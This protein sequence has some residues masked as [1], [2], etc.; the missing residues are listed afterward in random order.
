MASGLQR[1][2]AGLAFSEQ[3]G[4]ERIQRSQL[5]S[6]F[7]LLIAQ[8]LLEVV[9]RGAD[10]LVVNYSTCQTRGAAD[11]SAVT[12][13]PGHQP[14]S[15]FFCF[16][17]SFPSELL[18]VYHDLLSYVGVIIRTLNGCFYLWKKPL[19]TEPCLKP[20]KMKIMKKSLLNKV[21]KDSKSVWCVG[22]DPTWGVFQTTPHPS[23][24]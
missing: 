17:S 16:A 15:C 3:K 2:A 18:D 7:L 22:L 1:F 20:L 13:H 5:H 6:R 4:G 21:L 9:S 8:Q 11:F 23:T 12:F 10:S 14:S 19:K 24:L